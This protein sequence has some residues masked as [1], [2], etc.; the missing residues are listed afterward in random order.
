[1]NVV[2]FQKCLKSV[3]ETVTVILLLFQLQF[4][5]DWKVLMSFR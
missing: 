3:F 1:M 2:L 5:I 4:L